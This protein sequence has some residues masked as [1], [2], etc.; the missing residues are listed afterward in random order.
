[1]L[2]RA[3]KLC[4]NPLGYSLELVKMAKATMSKEYIQSAADLLVT[5]GRPRYTTVWNLLVSDASRAGLDQIDF[6]WGKPVYGGAA[7]AMPLISIYGRYKNKRGEVGVVVPIWLPLVAMSR[8][9]EELI[10][11]TGGPIEDFENS[12]CV[13][14]SRL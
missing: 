8:L 2:S 11:M 10:R 13:M 5:R 7:C 9:R 14:A 3:G 1:M 6:G 4:K 12:N